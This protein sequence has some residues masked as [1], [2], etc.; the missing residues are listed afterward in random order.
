MLSSGGPIRTLVRPVRHDSGAI[1]D[2]NSR[3]ITSICALG[4]ESHPLLAIRTPFFDGRRGN[5][6]ARFGN[7]FGAILDANLRTIAL[8]RT[9][10][11]PS[12]DPNADFDAEEAII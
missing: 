10:T 1:L 8:R 3:T 11:P 9:S 4:D 7:D 2:A 5:H 6:F 12:G